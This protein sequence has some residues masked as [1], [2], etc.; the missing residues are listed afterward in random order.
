MLSLRGRLTQTLLRFLFLHEEESFYINQLAKTLH[1]DRGNLVK[2]IKEIE[3]LGLIQSQFHGNQKHCKLNKKCPLYNEY[4]SIVRKTLGVDKELAP[5]LKK[6]SGIQTAWIYGSYASQKMDAF[7]DLDLLIVG[8]HSTI[9]L[10][11]K[12]ALFEKKYGRSVNSVS[13]A[14][15]EF[16]KKMKK[17]DSFLKDVFK[18]PVVKIL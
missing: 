11:E 16:D 10:Y 13:F 5:L 7:S 6:I 4:Q 3:S 9:D 12:L 8:T 1:L 14:P 17:K 18:K 15:Q 2:K